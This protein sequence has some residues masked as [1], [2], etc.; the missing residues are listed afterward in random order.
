MFPKKCVYE[1]ASYEL[2]LMKKRDAAESDGMGFQ[3][4]TTYA[5]Y[6]L[7]PDDMCYILGMEENLISH[8]GKTNMIR[9]KI[10]EI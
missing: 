10:E 3:S 2:F 9:Y 8:P 6:Y 5:S 1:L 4:L 7:N